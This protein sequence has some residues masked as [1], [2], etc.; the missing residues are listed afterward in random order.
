M[1]K[2]ITLRNLC[3]IGII[4]TFIN[5]FAAKVDKSVNI[6]VDGVK[7]SYWLYVPDNCS[8]NAPVV[9]ALHGASG[10]ST[11]KSPH[12]NPIADKEGFIVVYPQGEPIYFPV[13]GGTVT[14]WDATGEAN[15]DVVFIKAI[16]NEIDN[17]YGIDRN[18]VYCCGFSNG[19]MMTYAMSNACSDVFAAFASISGFPLNEFHFRHTGTRPIPFLHIHGKKDDFVKYSLMPVIRDEIVARNGA[20]PVAKKTTVAGKYDKSIYEATEGG[21]PYIYYEIDDMGHS[22]FTDNTE[23]GS[24]SLTM[25]NFFKKY[26]L[27]TP[28]D[29]TLKWM[30]RI[31][32]EGFDPS[33]HG[34]I[35]N[36]GTMVLLFGDEKQDNSNH[37]VYH[38][39]QFDKGK[40]RLTF[41]SSG[42][43]GKKLTVKIRRWSDN[44]K[45]VLNTT[46]N[47][48]EDSSL[49][50]DVEDGWGQYRLT[51]KKESADDKITVSELKIISTDSGESAIALP[52]TEYNTHPIKYYSLSG[53][54]LSK[55]EREI[56]ICRMSDGKVRKIYAS[57][58]R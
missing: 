13:F 16:L 55:P 54:P 1:K 25:W 27:D 51:I 48:G 36:S 18:R 56:T 24:S 39:L 45:D 57:Q 46:V 49:D 35:L 43:A 9:F 11:D 17:N 47:V 32:E 7:R 37:N 21:F 4:A 40:Y 29:K 33:Q 2:T 19:G 23:D 15:K 53:T 34:F 14:G 12:F 20:C 42:P 52:T 3:L 38:S 26:T 22:D 8:K 30:P 31:E 28:C 50:F 58:Y 41:K 44:A 10:H 6:T 5:G